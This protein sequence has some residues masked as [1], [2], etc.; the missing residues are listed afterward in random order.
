MKTSRLSSVVRGFLRRVVPV[1]ML[2]VTQTEDRATLR[3][4][5]SAALGPKS[6]RDGWK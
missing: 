4:D 2:S 3:S 5:L 1:I 6:K